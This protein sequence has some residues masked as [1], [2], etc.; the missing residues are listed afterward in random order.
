MRRLNKIA[1][2]ALVTAVIGT[3]CFADEAR[4]RALAERLIQSDE[5][6]TKIVK[7]TAA[8][9]SSSYHKYIGPDLRLPEI[10]QKR[11]IASEEWRAAEPQIT[12]AYSNAAQ[13]LLSSDELELVTEFLENE[14][15][16]DALQKL[17]G[18][19]REALQDL[20]GIVQKT[21]ANIDA[22]VAAEVPE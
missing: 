12:A 17:T 22:R 5:V 15:L 9:R 20:Y 3:N 16:Q 1:T 11:Q 7:F 10:K 19:Q 13:R 18:L 21:Q 4:E 8:G 6:Q 2:I 14:P